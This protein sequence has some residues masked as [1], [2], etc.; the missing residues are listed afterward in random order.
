M[1]PQDFQKLAELLQ[2]RSGLVL[3]SEKAYLAESRLTPVARHWGFADVHALIRD[4]ARGTGSG[5][6]GR[7]LDDV[8]EAMTTNE[9]FFFRDQKP[10]EQFRDVML[11]AMLEAR[12]SN[13]TIRIWSAACAMGQEPYSLAM[14]IKEMGARLDGWRIDIVATDISRVVLDRARKGAYSQLEVQR[15]LPIQYLAKYFDQDGQAWRLKPDVRKMVEFRE[16]NLLDDPPAGGPFDIVF[17]R[18]VLIYFDQPTK[19]Q[20]LHRIAGVMAPDGYLTL[21][22]AETVLGVSDRFRPIPKQRGLYGRSGT[23]TPLAASGG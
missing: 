11:P 21:G 5:R 8:V 18:N 19:A 16:H 13:R 7:L 17:C 9:S 10:F 14:V 3:G 1:N 15:G 2:R 22:G 4:L 20:V 6:D 23:S 12:A